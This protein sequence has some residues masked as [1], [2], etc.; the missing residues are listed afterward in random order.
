MPDAVGCGVIGGW[1]GIRI[2]YVA[3]A[4]YARLILDFPFVDVFVVDGGGEYVVGGALVAG[5]RYARARV[6][7]EIFFR[8]AGKLCDG[9]R[10][11]GLGSG[12]RISNRREPPTWP[13]MA[14]KFK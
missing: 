5:Q 12:L 6:E 1:V 4:V 2:D 14:F 11:A 10:E 9:L 3:E 13:A 7:E 8:R